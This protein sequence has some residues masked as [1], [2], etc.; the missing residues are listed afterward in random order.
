MNLN[1]AGCS[2]APQLELPPG[3]FQKANDIS[4][5][6]EPG[7]Q[8]DQPDDREQ[9]EEQQQDVE[10]HLSRSGKN[11]VRLVRHRSLE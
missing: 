1:F 11:V 5:Y 2:L 6:F 4:V 8:H 10:I 9:S 7:N 3:L